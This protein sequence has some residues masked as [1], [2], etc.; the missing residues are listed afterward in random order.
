[1]L[2]NRPCFASTVWDDNMKQCLFVSSTCPFASTSP[3]SP[4]STMSAVTTVLTS[5]TSPTPTPIENC[6]TDCTGLV[7]GNYQSC[8]SCNVFASCVNEYFYD[9]RPCAGNL[10][11]DDNVKACVSLSSTCPR[12]V[13]TATSPTSAVSQTSSST[14]LTSAATTLS[15][16]SATT[17]PTTA[18]P[19]T[20]PVVI[21]NCITGCSALSD[22]DYQSCRSCS[23][24]ATCVSGIFYDGRPCFPS[25]FWDDAL[26]RCTFSSSTCP[27][28]I[29][30]TS[31]TSPGSPTSPTSPMST[32][33]TTSPVTQTTVT[34]VPT[35]RVTLT[36]NCVLS[37]SGIPD[38]DYQSCYS[39]GAYATCINGNII[40]NRS[41]PA[42][43]V[44]D[45]TFK[46]CLIFSQTCP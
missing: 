25:S 14:A 13:T 28:Q 8:I 1:L 10:K 16:G 18:N 45:D 34:T 7:N 5:A 41:C 19:T 31:V 29:V 33:Q 26:K 27:N 32:P 37:C 30:S 38:G 11:W 36:T 15:T 46:Q 24:Y 39:C 35:S 22:G 20:S 3:T 40:D 6:A 12:L 23:V 17:S 2:D 21:S 42:N 44:W 9:H 4:V 43:L